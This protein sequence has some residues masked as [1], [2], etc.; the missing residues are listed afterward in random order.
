MIDLGI[1]EDTD[2]PCSA[3]V[4]FLKNTTIW[5]FMIRE[6]NKVTILEPRPMP[7]IDDILINIT[8]AKFISKLDLT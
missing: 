6:F 5:D 3:P 2:S 1:I 4:V 7:R 8:K